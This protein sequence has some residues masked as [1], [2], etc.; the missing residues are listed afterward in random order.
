[1]RLIFLTIDGNHNA[2][3]RLAAARI[4][5]EHGLSVSLGLYDAAS[6]RSEADW[7]RLERDLARADFVFGARLFGEEMIRPLERALSEIAAPVLIITSN[8][9][10]IR[11]TRI[12]KFSLGQR[13]DEQ[14]SLI[15]EW[16]KKLRPQNG[17]VNEARRQLAVLRNL[18]KVL[19]LIPGK[20]RDIHTYVAAHQYWL[21]NSPENLFRLFCLLI[22]RYIPSAG[23]SLPQ[24]DPLIYPEVA[25]FH[26]T[27]DKPFESTEQ[28]VKWERRQPKRPPTI[29][30]VGLLTLRTV[31]LSGNTAHLTALTE[32]LEQRGVA[33]RLAYA[34]G[35]DQRPAIERFFSA[36]PERRGL[37][38]AKTT[39]A[40]PPPI[41]LLVNVSGFG[42]VG[43]PAESKP[44]EA[45][46][47]L[48]AL[49]VGYLGL[50]PLAFQRVEEWR[51]D[52]TGL[53]PVQLALSVALPELDGASDPL[54][55]GGPSSH[56]EHFVPVTEQITTI[57]DR[58]AARVALRHK[59]N[60][61]KRV[62]VIIYNFPPNLGNV[63]TAAYLDVFASL[64]EL[65][66]SLQEAG[67]QVEVPA[68]AEDL[69]KTLLG[70]AALLHGTDAQIA[71]RFP[72]DQYRRLFPAEAEIEP[73]WGRAPGELLNDGRN[74]FILGHHF[75]NVFVGVQPSF[76][77]ER[78]PMRLLMAKDAAPNHAFAAFYTWLREVYRA[79]AL[80]HFGTH[81]A[82]EFMPGKQAGLGPECWPLRLLGG[83]PNF[84]CY[85]VNNPSEAT[86]AKRRGG[87]TLVS[88]LTPPLQQAGLYKGLRQLK[89]NLD[90]YRQRPNPAAVED[91]R[92][93]A[94]KLGINVVASDDE[95]AVAAIGHELLQIEQ[96]MVPM[97]L[98]VLGRPP[99]ANELLDFL[100]L[101]T[102]FH[103]LDDQRRGLLHLLAILEGHDYAALRE[104]SADDSPA[105]EVLQRLDRH[106][107]T[108]I[109]ALVEGRSEPIF[110]ALPAAAQSELRRFVAD[111]LERLTANLELQGLLHG[112]EG[113]FIAPSP[114]NDVVRNPAVAPTGRNLHALDPYRVPTP[115][116]CQS[117]GRLARELLARLSADQGKLPDTVAVVL[118]GTDNLKNDCEGVALALELL[119]AAPVTDELGSVVDVALRPLSEL[120]RPR[121]DVVVTVS[122]IFRDLLG[123][124][125]GLLDRAARLAACADEP[126]EQ[127]F[128]RQHALT[129]AAE[130]GISVEDAASRVFSNAPGSYGAN[131][132]FLVES[133]NWEA[134][135]QLSDAFLSRKSFV[136]G[137]HGEWHESRALMEKALSTVDATFQNVDSFEVGIT[138]I[139][140]YY[141]NLGGVTKSVERLRGTRPPVLVADG[142][143]DSQRVSSLEQMVRL[144]S[145]TKLLNPKW[146]E[147]MLSHGFE[148]AREIE[149][150]VNNTYGWSATTN[151]VE[152]WVYGQVA[153]TFVLD[154]EMRDRLTEL[155][156]S[157]AGGIVRRL[158]EAHGRGFWDADEEMIEQLQEIYEELEDRLEG[159]A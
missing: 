128:V 83:L 130:L 97:G 80:V 104:A 12:G 156:P 66:Q 136:I 81:G 41:D 48:G 63:G 52:A 115:A 111:M 89:D 22:E 33:V 57:A 129:Q 91:L 62:G 72:V 137:K 90:A 5:R 109:T 124:Q 92:L 40:A 95:R 47:A 139:D 16:I 71:D 64:F 148:G 127:N 6:L 103:P 135:D 51:A 7:Q 65:L 27:A 112:L 142:L 61:E 157:A 85:S 122:G 94:S 4:E 131:V 76:G 101:A 144:E 114:S 146:Y 105:Q 87:A 69:R 50:V 159:V 9:V 56:A 21:N 96:R 18:S 58:I 36:T 26:P 113:G 17:G 31:A 25:L 34:S 29:G 8:P 118:W 39:T 28:Y 123:N 154:S 3:L 35:L 155:N 53:T 88:Y 152:G 107:R 108:L 86:I 45:A 37:F 13:D 68:S 77:Y 30:T 117:A 150:R 149:T 153:E 79:D 78:D 100:A 138:E 49:D 151:A 125:M 23:K 158:L 19:K 110:K 43:G 75:G 42:L 11:H 70:E 15:R 82:L 74:F 132:N 134:D 119:G 73:F 126:L 55:F 46:K 44:L 1:M 116:A 145:R 133:S 38:G 20:A 67:Y 32:A 141:E 143:G 24:A 98:H 10:L 121:I 14:P 60:A 140:N 54:V 99:A 59:A 93:Q 84:Y 2:A 102:T 147:A 106:A 120:G